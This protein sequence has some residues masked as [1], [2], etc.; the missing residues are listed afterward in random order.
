MLASV[1]NKKKKEKKKEKKKSHNNQIHYADSLI[2]NS[3]ALSFST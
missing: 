1:M 2:F 3:I